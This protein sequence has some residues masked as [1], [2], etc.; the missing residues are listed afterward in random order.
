MNVIIAAGTAVVRKP[1]PDK[2][3]FLGRGAILSDRILLY[4][5]Y[6]FQTNPADAT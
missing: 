3:I 2:E 5:I 6:L 1:F 4:A